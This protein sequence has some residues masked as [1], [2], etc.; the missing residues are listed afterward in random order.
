MHFSGDSASLDNYVF[1]S[2]SDCFQNVSQGKFVA[3]DGSCLLENAPLDGN[4]H[5]FDHLAV[6]GG[7]HKRRALTSKLLSSTG[8]FD[9]KIGADGLKST[10]PSV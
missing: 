4:F 5:V 10:L 6:T 2:S 3:E 1:M 9:A 8:S 7:E